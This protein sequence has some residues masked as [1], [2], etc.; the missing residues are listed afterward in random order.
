MH[1]D[2]GKTIFYSPII[3]LDTYVVVVLKS[4]AAFEVLTIHST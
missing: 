1:D 3:K 2:I 4:N